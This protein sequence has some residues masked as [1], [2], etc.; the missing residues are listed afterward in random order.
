MTTIKSLNK[1]NILI[2]GGGGE[3]GQ[4]IAKSASEAGAGVTIW[5]KRTAEK[6]QDNYHYQIIDTSDEKA[7]RAAFAELE[8]EDKLPDILINCVGLFTY[9]KPF[10]A[11]EL[12]EFTKLFQV[13]TVSCFLTCREALRRYKEKLTIINLSSALSQKA[14]PLTAAYSASKAAIDSL[15]RAIAGEY[16][17]KGVM[18]VS[19]NPGP[20]AGAMLDNGV[21][22][23]AALVG[24]P[25]QAVRQ[26][27]LDVI[28]SGSLTAKEEISSLALFIPM[29]KAPSLQG[30]QINHAGGFS[31]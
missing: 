16:G 12:N 3:I 19:I 2:P 15:T 22:E 21:K 9:L 5:D 24:A 28:P 27:I 4:N 10:T 7:V 23:I 31:L 26:Q 6:S 30:K 18:A 11:L 13:N 20:V 14:I 17:Q 1:K 8:Q 29:N 25:E